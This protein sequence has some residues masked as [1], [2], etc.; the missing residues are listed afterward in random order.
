LFEKGNK[1]G[2]KTSEWIESLRDPDTAERIETNFGLT[3]RSFK[4]G[5]K[6]ERRKE[7]TLFRKFKIYPRARTIGLLYSIIII[8]IIII[9]IYHALCTISQIPQT[10]RRPFLS[11]R[12][13]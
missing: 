3:Q 13:I 12:C 6:G 10:H 8:I 11:H 9:I 5:R 4:K 2:T 1:S 7:N